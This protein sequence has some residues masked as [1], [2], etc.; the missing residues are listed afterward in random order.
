MF[1]TDIFKEVESMNQLVIKILKEGDQVLNVGYRDGGMYV[2]VRQPN[3][4]VL[5]YSIA[6]DENGQPRLSTETL[7]QITHGEGEVEALVT[8]KNGNQIFSLTA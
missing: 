3:E 1:I 6:Q 7:I 2:V 4:E 8:D 5:V